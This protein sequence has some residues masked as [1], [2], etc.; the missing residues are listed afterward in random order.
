MPRFLILLVFA[1]NIVSWPSGTHG[2]IVDVASDAEL[3]LAISNA[4]GGET[5]RL[6]PGSYGRVTIRGGGRVRV[7]SSSETAPGRLAAPV[8]ITSAAGT[9]LSQLDSIDINTSDHWHIS[10]VAVR[11]SS[12]SIAVNVE[13]SDGFVF[14][15]SHVAFGDST[16]WSQSDWVNRAGTGIF[17]RSAP[18]ARIADNL[19]ESVDHGISVFYDSPHTV[20]R[21]NIVDG[22]RGDGIRGLSDYGLFHRNIMKNFV[23]VDDN[24]DDCF[25][26]WSFDNGQVGTGVVTGTILRE[27]FCLAYEDESL[28][29][30]ATPQGI[31]MFDG[32]FQD[33]TIENNILATDHWHGISVFG[34]IN[35]SILNNTAVDLNDRRPGP[36]WIRVYQDKDGSD[37]T[38]NTIANNLMMDPGQ[39]LP[40]NSYENNEVIRFADYDDWFVDWR[41]NDFSLL[42]TAPNPDVGAR[43]VPE[44][45]GSL[46]V[47]LF[48]AMFVV[49]FRGNRRG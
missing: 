13:N 11:P 16:N 46:A 19:F 17:V 28:P 49:L 47:S 2:Q 5:I 6:A 24:H 34:A 4:T 42:S 7:G 27:N 30:R 29:F 44:P 38:G 22:I 48:Y 43:I 18:N 25:Q 20:V 1:L 32:D 14:T 37:A 23:A 26:S 3:A 39:R 8:M 10:R 35:V 36:P 45:S 9:E 41:N 12:E 40:G 21:G 33:W 15:D 31:G